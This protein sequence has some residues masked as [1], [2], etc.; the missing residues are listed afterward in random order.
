MQGSAFPAQHFLR[1][2][3]SDRE[4]KIL[5]IFKQIEI[6]C[7]ERTELLVIKLLDLLTHWADFIV[8][9]FTSATPVASSYVASLFYF[10]E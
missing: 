5:R 9:G 4:R 2:H 6:M 10:S 3:A 7:S 1:Y 8:F